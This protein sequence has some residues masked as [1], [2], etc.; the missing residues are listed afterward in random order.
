MGGGVDRSMSLVERQ[1]GE[2]AGVASDIID[3]TPIAALA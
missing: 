3:L 1:S 2:M